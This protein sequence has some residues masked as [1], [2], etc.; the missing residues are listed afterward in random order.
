M[1]QIIK[2]TNYEP[3][4]SEKISENGLMEITNGL[5]FDA[6][7]EIPEQK[8][9]SVPLAQLATLGA[10]V[11]S[12]LPALRTVS[13]TTTINTSGLYQL[14]NAAVGDTLKVAK[15]GNFWGAFKTADGVSKF[16]QLQSAGPLT[17][18]TQTVAAINPATMMMAVALFSVEQKL[19]EIEKM[20][21]QIISFLEIEKESEI[22]ADVEMLLNIISKYKLNWDN[23]HFIASNHKLVLDI[24]R[25]ARKNMN[26][27]QK[28]VAE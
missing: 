11:S 20:Q 16:A 27:Y 25:T 10:G 12:L 9:L 5:L 23:E 3:V 4:P 24:Q 2:M 7:A 18:T 15:N 17:T 13:Q 6:R 19:G 28:R 1:A 14:A 21:R 26:V 8:T 22:E